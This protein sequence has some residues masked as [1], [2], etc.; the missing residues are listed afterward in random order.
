MSFPSKRNSFIF[1]LKAMYA[2]EESYLFRFAYGSAG[3][4]PN[5]PGGS[6]IT[7]HI[8]LLDHAFEESPDSLPLDQRMEIG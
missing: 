5:I 8:E 4:P 7:Y 3:L 1:N 2:D 6:T